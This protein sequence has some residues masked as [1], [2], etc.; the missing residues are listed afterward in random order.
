MAGR[1]V[2]LPPAFD[3]FQNRHFRLLWPAT[4]LYYA[5]RWMQMFLL[6][7][8]V[9]VQTDSPLLVSLVGFFA[10]SPLLVL[11]V[12]GGALA[13]RVDRRRLLMA[14]IAMNFVGAITMI[15]LLSSERAVFWHAYPV[16]ALSG[17]AWALDMPS[18]RAMILDILGRKGVANGLA[19]DAV[20]MSLSFMVGPALAGT[21]IDLADVAGGYVAMSLFYLAAAALVSQ[22]SVSKPQPSNRSYASIIT[23]LGKGLRYALG[24]RYL[25]TLLLIQLLMNLLLFSFPPMIPVI[26]RDVLN[27]GPGLI[28][29]LQSTGGLGSLFGAL[30]IASAGN[31]RYHGR[32]LLGGSLVAMA[33]LLMFSLSRSYAG[34]VASLLVLGLGTAGFAPMLFT[35]LMLLA[36]DDMRGMALGLSSL[37]IGVGPFG[38]LMVGGVANAVSPTFA[39]SLNGALGLMGLTLIGVLVPELRRRTTGEE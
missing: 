34:S 7:W 14:S 12:I 9:L 29:V 10:W 28:G 19:L 21:L 30:V 4:F 3:A 16:I 27:V 22:V 2:H 13:E 36:R 35:I 26:A 8:F 38:T 33:G 1:T 24:H 32:V 23:D 5:S 11:G 6:A 18:R 39:L 25:R 15:A 31:I 37:V 17:T 20:G